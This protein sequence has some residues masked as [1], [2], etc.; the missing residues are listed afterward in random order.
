LPFSEE[1]LLS[2]LEMMAGGCSGPLADECS[3]A[4]A[5]GDNDQDGPHREY[6]GYRRWDPAWTSSTARIVV[7]GIGPDSYRY[8]EV[9]GFVRTHLYWP[10]D[11][12]GADDTL[13]DCLEA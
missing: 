12:D 11:C 1:V 6:P 4:P 5:G 2:G 7:G 9:P 13:R 8:A 3:G 10:P